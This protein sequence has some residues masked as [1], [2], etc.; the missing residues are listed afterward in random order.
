[1]H[2]SAVS[3]YNDTAE[4]CIGALLTYAV[5]TNLFLVPVAL[6]VVALLQRFAAGFAP[7]PAR[8]RER[9]AQ[10]H[11]QRGHPLRTAQEGDPAEFEF[12]ARFEPVGFLPVADRSGGRIGEVFVDG[13]RVVAERRQVA[14]QLFDVLAFGGPVGEVA[15]GGHRTVE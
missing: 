7:A 15:V 5:A 9:G 13:A 2:S 4:L 12:A 1:M 6:P 14:L 11:F 10:G 3:L 8:R